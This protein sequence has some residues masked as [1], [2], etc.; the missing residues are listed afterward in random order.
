MSPR[1]PLALLALTAIVG[2][3]FTACARPP[4]QTAEGARR[5]A[6]PLQ[7]VVDDLATRTRVLLRAQDEHIWR[8]WTEGAP[9]SLD[10]FTEEARA[11]YTPE[12]VQTIATLRAHTQ[13]PLEARALDQLRIHFVGEVLARE[14]AAQNQEVTRLS[15]TLTF[16]MGEVEHRVAEL[17][18]LLA[19]ERNALRRQELQRLAGAALK[20]LVE[21][22]AARREKT[23]TALAALGYEDP[24]AFA[25]DLRRTDLSELA[26]HAQRLL[27]VTEKPF[28]NVVQ[29]LTARELRL[30]RDRVRARDLPRMFRSRDVDELFA[31]GTTRTRVEET[32]AGMG[33]GTA[34]LPQLRIDARELPE[35]NPHPLT[36]AIAVPEDVR[37]SFKPREGLRTQAAYLHEMGHAL[38]AAL[39]TERRF[40][41]AKLGSGSVTKT[42]SQLFELLVEDPVWLTRFAQLTG[43]RLD[44]YLAASAAW[45]LYLARLAAGR[46]LFELAAAKQPDASRE[47]LFAEHLGRALQVPIEA[48]DYA[49]SALRQDPFFG[50]VIA[51]EGAFLSH[52]LQAQLKARFGPSWWETKD[53]GDWLRSLASHGHAL[54]ARELAREAGETRLNPD[55]FLLRL[56]STLKLPILLPLSADPEAEK[57]AATPAPSA[58]NGQTP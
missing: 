54:N 57:P 48:E 45:D 49:V 43:A 11:L 35:K 47:A 56:T 23:R 51:L 53:A 42:W 8:H 20:P 38:H 30:P 37:L 44:R 22:Q 52:Q 36:L 16:K 27:E 32:L 39:T 55:A 17:D 6:H 9:L 29:Q 12:A 14:L 25:A 4:S 24:L 46:F 15:S 33:L 26:V 10:P 34:T 40:P 28:A 3:Y 2:L 41:L 5:P 58:P 50:E 18:R 21:A 13:D 31:R 19:R 1:S 7:P